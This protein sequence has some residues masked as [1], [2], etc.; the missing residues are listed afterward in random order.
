MGLQSDSRTD[1]SINS[2]E[3][4]C[5][6]FREKQFCITLHTKPNDRW[7]RNVNLDKIRKVLE[8]NINYFYN[9]VIGKPYVN[10]SQDLEEQI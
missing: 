1:T 3:R 8:E 9:P 5:S 6:A 10:K 7:I 4:T 2:I